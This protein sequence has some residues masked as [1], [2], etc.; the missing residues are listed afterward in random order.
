LLFKTLTFKISYELPPYF[1]LEIITTLSTGLTIIF[2]D[3]KSLYFC[4]YDMP[5][6]ADGAQ[7]DLVE[8]KI[9]DAI[10]SLKNFESAR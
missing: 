5:Y 2:Q 6:V 8:G 10:S 7:N 1:D 9:Y 3:T 4:G